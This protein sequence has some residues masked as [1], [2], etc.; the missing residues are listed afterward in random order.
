MLLS[1]EV[2]EKQLNCDNT[3][4]NIDWDR[5]Q[6]FLAVTEFTPSGKAIFKDSNRMFILSLVG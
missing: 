5:H 3:H 1:S 6:T 2:L 4:V